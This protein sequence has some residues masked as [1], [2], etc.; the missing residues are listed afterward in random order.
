M[1][2]LSPS[3]IFIP[4]SSNSSSQKRKNPEPDH[5][6][7]NVMIQDSTSPTTAGTQPGSGPARLEDP[8]KIIENNE[9]SNIHPSKRRKLNGLVVVPPPPLPTNNNKSPSPTSSKYRKSRPPD[10]LIKNHLPTSSSTIGSFGLT[11]VPNSSSSYLSSI[12]ISSQYRSLPTTPMSTKSISNSISHPPSPSSKSP[13]SVPLVRSNSAFDRFDDPTPRPSSSSGSSSKSSK[14][15]SKKS[16]HHHHHHHHKR[17][18]KENLSSGLSPS[19]QIHCTAQIKKGIMKSKYNKH[20][21]SQVVQNCSKSNGYNSG[22]NL[23]YPPTS[24][25]RFSG[26]IAGWSDS[27][28]DDEKIKLMDVDRQRRPN[29]FLFHICSYHQL[30]LP[31]PFAP[32]EVKPSESKGSPNLNS[33]AVGLVSPLE[34]NFPLSPPPSE[35]STPSTVVTITMPQVKPPISCKTLRDYELSQV[36][37]CPQRRHDLVMDEHSSIRAIK[38]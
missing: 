34:S 35:V 16:S 32:S 22:K 9:T 17:P 26:I 15:K 27:N 4:I 31:R 18:S 33:Y 14:T 36:L 30:H 3:S 20:N 25:F 23:L 19:N 1:S 5:S 2:E 24:S 7:S 11:N 28:N 29:L 37:R 10:I 6:N 12:G 21:F 8:E 13:T 38:E